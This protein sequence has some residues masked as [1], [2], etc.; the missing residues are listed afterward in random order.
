LPQP[1]SISALCGGSDA[2]NAIFP[3]RRKKAANLDLNAM[4]YDVNR[5]INDGA[6]CP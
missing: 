6:D 1:T 3:R 5:L 2:K 4:K